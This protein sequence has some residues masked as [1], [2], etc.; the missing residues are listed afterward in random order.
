MHLNLGCSQYNRFGLW[1]EV[2]LAGSQLVILKRRRLLCSAKAMLL[3]DRVVN[4]PA[5][6]ATVSVRP[7]MS[8]SAVEI[9]EV[10]PDHETVAA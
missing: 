4:I 2:V 1:D 10:I 9:Q 8:N 3:D 6:H 5:V 7:H